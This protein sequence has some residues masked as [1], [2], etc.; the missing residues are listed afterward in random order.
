MFFFIEIFS[1][2]SH[3]WFSSVV[4]VSSFDTQVQKIYTRKKKKK[5]FHVGMFQS[6]PTQNFKNVAEII[7]FFRS[8]AQRK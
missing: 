5:Y 7:S 1:Q 2:F 6:L 8:Y 4:W 3:D